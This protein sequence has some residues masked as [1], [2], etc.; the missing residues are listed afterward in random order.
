MQ[1]M[2]NGKALPI[3]YVLQVSVPGAVAERIFLTNP[4]G[5][6]FHFLFLHSSPFAVKQ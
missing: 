4:L 2:Q 1:G 3:I 5:Y 6:V